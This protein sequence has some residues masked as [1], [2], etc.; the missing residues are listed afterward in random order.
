MR[1]LELITG[2]IRSFP[3][4]LL[5]RSGGMIGILFQLYLVVWILWAAFISSGKA[6]EISAIAGLQTYLHIF[7]YPG[8]PSFVL[9]AAISILVPYI[10]VY[11]LWIYDLTAGAKK[12]RHKEIQAYESVKIDFNLP[13][14]MELGM[15]SSVS[16]QISNPARYEIENIWIRTIFPECVRCDSPQVSLGLLKPGTSKSVS[17]AFVPLCAGKAD[18]GLVEFYFE[19]K[20]KEFRK[21]PFSLGTHEVSCSYLDISTEVPDTLK[22]GHATPFYITLK[23]NSQM[24]LTGLN[25]KCFFSKGIGFD[26]SGFMLANIGPGSVRSLSF[27]VVPTTLHEASIGYF[28]I[29]FHANGNEC[30]VGPVDLGKH[31]IR[32]PELDVKLNVPDNF[33]KEV[34]A[35][36][37]I[38]VENH[39]D[40]PLSNLRFTNCFSSQ[41]ECDSPVVSIPD[42]SPGASRYVSL[43]I[44]PRTGGNIDLGNLNIS[45]DVNGITCHKE[46][47]AM[48]IHK[49]L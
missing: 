17:I 49:I 4:V 16:F 32:V 29:R 26:S 2:I 9:P 27:N 5:N 45:F 6:Y 7:T 39:S 19:M 34:P 41:I 24:A 33:Y 15:G 40:I 14:R 48:G 23:N 8:V 36:I 46:P 38:T 25:V 42:I 22:F 44:R 43:S 20:G 35:T 37:G 12:R 3:H 30:Y 13:P 11:L 18:M 1:L 10:P 31:K 28:N 21:E 47:I